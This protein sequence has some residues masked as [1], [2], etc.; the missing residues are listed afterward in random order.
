MFALGIWPFGSTAFDVAH[1]LSEATRLALLEATDPLIVERADEAMKR[2]SSLARTHALTSALAFGTLF[3]T[4]VGT[5]YQPLSAS[6]WAPELR[7][8]WEDKSDKT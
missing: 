8:A 3:T 2:P 6:S 1:M 7:Q 4:F 5:L